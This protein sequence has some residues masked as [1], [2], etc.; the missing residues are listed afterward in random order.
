VTLSLTR[1]TG[2]FAP[3]FFGSW[4]TLLQSVSPAIAIQEGQYDRGYGIYRE[5]FKRVNHLLKPEGLLINAE[6][7]KHKQSGRYAQENAVPQ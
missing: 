1:L 3:N 4:G 2:I 7:D 5:S 6:Q